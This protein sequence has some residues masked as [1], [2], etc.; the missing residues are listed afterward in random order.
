MAAT[1]R[2]V[3]GW[4]W[5]VGKRIYTKQVKQ[6]RI[7]VLESVALKDYRMW[8]TGAMSPCRI[9]VCGAPGL[10]R[11]VA[12]SPSWSTIGLLLRTG[13]STTGAT[14]PAFFFFS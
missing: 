4:H 2:R 11:L 9:T 13:L 8:S 5:T 6:R 1:E 7:T 10:R 12:D 14:S 3:R